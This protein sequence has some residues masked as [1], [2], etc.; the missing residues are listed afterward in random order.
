VLHEIIPATPRLVEK[1]VARERDP[2]RT[3]PL[4]W[5]KS[6]DTEM[7]IEIAS[8]E[9]AKLV[10]SVDVMQRKI[11]ALNAT[12]KPSFGK[13]LRDSAYTAYNDAKHQLDEAY[14]NLT[15]FNIP[16]RRSSPV[17]R[18]NNTKKISYLS[19]SDFIEQEK[20][21]IH[22]SYKTVF[23]TTE[24][25]VIENINLGAFEIHVRPR[26]DSTAEA[27]ALNPNPAI[28]NPVVTHPN[29]KNNTVCLGEGKDAY[30]KA[31]MEGRLCDALQIALSVVRNYGWRNPYLSISEWFGVNCGFCGH[32]NT[33]NRTFQCID[34]KVKGCKTCAY[35]GTARRC[36][37]CHEYRLANPPDE[38]YRCSREAH[39]ECPDCK[40]KVCG[41]CWIEDSCNLCYRRNNQA[42]NRCERVTRIDTWPDPCAGCEVRLCALCMEHGVLCPTCYQG[43]LNENPDVAR[44]IGSL[45]DDD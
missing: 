24:P 1:L 30:N 18:T 4:L 40:K 43:H 35:T 20:V 10:S 29:V 22:R 11:R 36:Y 5:E 31:V 17:A 13:A 27:Y 2:A 37:E 21:M 14:Y 34:C 44:L 6:E 23:I 8:R 32:L 38:C 9:T 28:S 42:C 45:R 33:P 7:Y 15:S 19:N 12:Q 39:N 16:E 25:I 41:R 3:D 26:V